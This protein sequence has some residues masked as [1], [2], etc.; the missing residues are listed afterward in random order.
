MVEEASIRCPRLLFGFTHLSF[1]TARSLRRVGGSGAESVLQFV[2]GIPETERLAAE[3]LPLRAAEPAGHARQAVQQSAL[4]SGHDGERQVGALG[5]GHAAQDQ[6]DGHHPR[7]THARLAPRPGRLLDGSAA[8][9]VPGG[10]EWSERPQHVQRS[11][12]SEPSEQSEQSEQSERGGDPD[13]S[14]GA[15]QQCG[16]RGA[17]A[18]H[19][20]VPCAVAGR[21]GRGA[22]QERVLSRTPVQAEE[23]EGH[24]G[25][26][27]EQRGRQTATSELCTERAVDGGVGAHL[28]VV[29]PRAGAHA[30]AGAAQPQA[31]PLLQRRLPGQREPSRRRRVHARPAEQRAV[32]GGARTRGRGGQASVAQRERARAG[33]LGG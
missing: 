6:A 5:Q 31:V 1:V 12:R 16:S 8:V 32:R 19:P 15:A 2:G 13:R 18:A 29:Q 26:Q 33:A 11:Q 21:A 20:V 17:A 10:F 9:L 14:T 23:G 27:R 22:P 25:G 24:Y 28:T 30:E 4:P 7:H 3:H